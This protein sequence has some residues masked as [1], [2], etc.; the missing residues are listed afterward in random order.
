V[1]VA[2]RTIFRESA[3]QAYRRGP[4][5]DIVPRLTSWPSIVCLWLLLAVLLVILA[6][7]WSVRVPSYIGTQGVILGSGAQA[8]PSGGGTV[9]ALFLLPDQSAH[10]RAGQPVHARIGSSGPAV[11]GAVAKVEPGVIS[12][13]TAR[14]K[15]RF[16][17]GGGAVGQTWTVVIVRFGSSQPLA[18]YGGRPLTA[19]VETGSQ[20]LLALFPAL[21]GLFGGAS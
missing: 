2:D 18:D 3:L 9:A 6:V 16:E 1:I 20:R 17:P 4:A 12:P 13:D 11:L 21:G 10:L 5:K 8:R 15:Y 7:A 19:Q 14:A